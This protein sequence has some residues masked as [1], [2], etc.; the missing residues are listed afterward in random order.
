MRCDD[1]G[2]SADPA[3]KYEVRLDFLSKTVTLTFCQECSMTVDAPFIEQIARNKA[4]VPL[5]GC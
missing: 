3:T 1:C 2:R 4:N 5:I